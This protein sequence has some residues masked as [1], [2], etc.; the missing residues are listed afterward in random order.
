MSQRNLGCPLVSALMWTAA[1]WSMP[2][3]RLYWPAT[4]FHAAATFTLTPNSGSS[5]TGTQ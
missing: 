3:P 4:P 5:S 2:S 1:S